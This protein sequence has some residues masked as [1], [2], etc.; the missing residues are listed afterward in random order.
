[1]I[2]L[3]DNEV[4][5][6]KGV[7]VKYLLY[8]RLF[9]FVFVLSLIPAVLY[10]ILYPRTYEIMARVQVLEE[11]EMG[12]AGIGLGDAMGLMRS[13]GL[14]ALSK[15][16]VNIDDELNVISSNAMLR[17]MAIDL[18]VNVDYTRPYS[19]YRLYDNAPYLL[20]A[21]SVT[22][23]RLVED[24]DFYVRL[25]KGNISIRTKSKMHGKHTFNVSSL[26]ALI[27]LPG[28]DFTL[29]YAPGKGKEALED[30]NITFHPASWTAEE[31]EEDFLIEEASK[32][33]TVIELSCTDYERN[34]GVNML[35]RLIYL[36][37]EDAGDYKNRESVK[38]LAYLDGRIDTLLQSLRV[39]EEN[40]AIYKN[41]NRLTDV[42]HDVEFYVEQ[43]K[44]IQVKL[45][46]LESQ[47]HLVKMMDDFVK[48]PANRYNLVPILLNQEGEGS[49][50]T[51][52]NNTLVERTRVIQN[53]NPDNPLALN[54]TEQADQLR[55]SV[56]LSIS[57]TREAAL[58]AI[59][60]IKKKE[61]ML[62]DKM[63]SFPDQERDYVELKRR[64]E[65]IQGVYL[66]LLQKREEA[67]LTQDLNHEKAKII[68]AAYVKSKPVAPRKLFAAIGIALLTLFIPV[69]YLFFKEQITILIEEYRRA[70]S[71][72]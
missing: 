52:Y 41:A 50:L 29:D 51:A 19:F 3:K 63:E 23:E 66:V 72:F 25:K 20:T 43:M 55:E 62:F 9:A 17:K 47:T 57:N 60:E 33:S 16:S 70:K 15:G 54:L 12:G 45:I 18:G 42:E 58:Q 22:N 14:G 48:N 68:D 27:S 21:D 49:P 5:G 30:M 36:Y 11:Q 10:L 2:E 34:R 39:V 13:F 67:A 59:N 8:W 7:I 65:I 69:A 71:Y 46:E 44:E 38:T 28:G 35:N 56:F 31:M 37:N 40:I 64:Q 53:S 26:P 6:L 32:T 4:I 61:K 1:M 24:V